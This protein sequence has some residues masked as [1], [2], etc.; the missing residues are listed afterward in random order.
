MTRNLVGFV[1]LGALISGCSG[2][3]VSGDGQS[4]AFA[5]GETAGEEVNPN[6]NVYFGDLHIH[7]RNS[8]DAYIFNVRTTPDDAYKFGMGEGIKHPAGYALK[9]EGPALDFMAVT[10]HA[11][12]LGHLP[13]MDKEGTR[14]SKLDM[15]KAMFSTDPD[16]IVKAFSVIGGSVRDGTKMD[17]VYDP[18]IIDSVWKATVDAAEKYNN[19]GKFTTFAA[20]E[21][22]ATRV[23]RGKGG[24]F[25]GGNLHRNVVFR[26]SAPGMPFGTLESTNPEDLWTWMDEQ[27]TAGNDVL[28]IPHNSNVSDG[29]M[30]K[31]E[32]YNGEQL[33]KTY[34]DK[35]MRNEPIAEITQVKGT[36][37]THPLLSPND[38]WAD[39]G[40]YDYLLSSQIKS[41]TVSG[42][43]VRQAYG[44]GLLLKGEGKGNPFRFGL[45]GSSDTHVAGGSFDEKNFW[46]KIGIVDATPEA[47]G[48]IPPGGKKSWEGVSVDP[49]AANWFSRWGASGY[50]A[51]WAEENT[52]EAIFDA[53][54]RKETYATTG[55][56]IKLRFFGGFGFTEAMLDDPEMVSKAYSTGVPMG[57]DLIGQGNVPGFIVWAMRDAMSAPLQRVQVVKVWTDGGK[58]N[59][60]V[61]DVACSDGG[62]VD[63]KT[64]RCPDNGAKV[65]LTDCSISQDKGAPELK[66]FWTDP[67]FNGSQRA[68]Y[69]VR[70]LENPVCRWSTWD[71]LRAKVPPNPALQKTIQER[72]WSSP[73]WY[74]P[75]A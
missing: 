68:S 21:Y 33:T 62:T 13:E 67:E 30:F 27:R 73:I 66:T 9:L 34:A 15:A 43:Y 71:A 14:L 40:I 55:T 74:V 53:M 49:N 52:R 1:A 3:S 46:S 64:Y 42:D 51:V 10:D 28:A 5:P 4:V 60:K 48:S 61:F 20:Y 7:T 31:M 58:A 38:E 63:P 59:E 37:E 65:N 16:E 2:T 17:G 45:I 32:T 70:V 39:F 54:R 75:T 35:R 8:F 36:S 11:A 23:T 47:R 57:G 26:G 56:R 29:E 18:K 19:P 22:T 69:Y 25:A 6:R 44:N 24:G 50:A 12:Y 72:A 41:K